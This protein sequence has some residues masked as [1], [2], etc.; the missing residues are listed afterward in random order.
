MFNYVHI[1]SFCPV[2]V[3]K[4]SCVWWW[5]VVCTSSTLTTKFI[6]DIRFIRPDKRYCDLYTDKMITN[7]KRFMKYAENA[8]KAIKDG[9]WGPDGTGSC[10]ST[11]KCG[12]WTDKRRNWIGQS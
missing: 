3:Y 8:V 5:C 4:L 2:K 7:V 6:G 12:D 10:L 11:L 9:H 1:F